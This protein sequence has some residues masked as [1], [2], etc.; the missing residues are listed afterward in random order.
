MSTLSNSHSIVGGTV[1]DKM[2]MFIIY[3]MMTAEMSEVGVA[4]SGY[5]YLIPFCRLTTLATLQHYKTLELIFPLSITSK[6]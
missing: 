3:Y 2:R 6:D 4:C 5:G 1:E